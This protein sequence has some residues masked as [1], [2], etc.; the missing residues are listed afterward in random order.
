MNINVPEE[1]RIHDFYTN[2]FSAK[3]LLNIL[4]VNYKIYSLNTITVYGGRYNQYVTSWTIRISKPA[5][6]RH[7]FFPT[8]SRPDQSKAIMEL[9]WQTYYHIVPM[10]RMS[11]A[12]PLFPYTSSWDGQELNEQNTS[13]DTCTSFVFVLVYKLWFLWTL[14]HCCYRDIHAIFVSRRSLLY[15]CSQY[16]PVLCHANLYRYNIRNY[17]ESIKLGK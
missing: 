2:E 1:T 6:V 10:L 5:R 9:K 17:V 8:T 7:F 16:V 12:I 3:F 13:S 4:P 11:G 15:V 14:L